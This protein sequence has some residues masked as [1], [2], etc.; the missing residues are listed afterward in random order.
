[1]IIIRSLVFAALCLLASPSLFAGSSA[2]LGYTPKYKPG[3]SHFEYVNPRA[4]KGGE[5]IIS[6]FGNYDSFNP[7]ILKG[8]AADRL[9]GLVFEPMMVQS[10]DEPYSVYAHIARDIKLAPNKLSVTFLLDPRARFSDG[11]PVTA[12]DVK[13]TFDIIRKKG[14]PFYKFFWANI[15]RAVILGKRKIRFDFTQ[16]NPEL[17]LIVAKMAI[18]SRK[19]VGKNDFAKHS[20]VIP[21]GSGPYIVDAYKLGRMVSYKRNPNYWARNL[22]TRR[23]MFNFDRIKIKYYRDSTAELEGLKAGEYDFKHVLHSKKWARDYRGPQFESGRIKKE[24]VKHQNNSGMQGFVFNLRKEIFKDRRVRKAISLAFDF[25]WSNK[26]LFYNQYKRCYSYFSNSELASSGL[27][28]GLE[29]QILNKY[30]KYLRK[31]IFTTEWRPPSTDQPGQL[32]K[33]LLEAKQLLQQAGWY[34]EDGVLRNKKGL[35]MEFE[36]LLAQPGFERILGPYAHNLRKLGII[37]NYRTVDLSLYVRRAKSFEF[38]MLVSSFRQSQSPGNEQFNYW[39]SK[40]ANEKGSR[41]II[42]IQ[43]PAVDALVKEV[44]QAPNRK[45]LV[46]ASRALDRVL[47]HG[48]YLVPNWYIETFRIAY[49]DKFGRP[50]K[51][52]KYY[53]ATDWVL[54][55]WWRVP[56]KMTAKP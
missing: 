39:H 45:Y 2:A 52:P 56:E 33:N 27:P 54:S 35:K 48:E 13:F 47:L 46:A 5:I 29:L 25:S 8:V 11:S 30:R 16:R 37:V 26:N 4:P 20:D 18:F 6:G 50:K 9:S 51:L 23:G 10:N 40:T 34:I 55:S 31:E 14:H 36:F 19:W 3:F 38:D 41:N 53:D 15:K 7:F 24:N 12:D 49:W 1:M 32:R 43:D 28:K 42:G 44:I 21:I 22:N 17:H